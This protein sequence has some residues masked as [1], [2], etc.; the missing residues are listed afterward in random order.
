MH[1]E[2]RL[3]KENT[4][5]GLTIV[6]GSNNPMER[7]FLWRNLINK[8]HMMQ[9]FPWII[10][11]DFNTIR[12]PQEKVGGATW[13]NYYCEDL[14]NCIR[15]A[16]LDDLR[17]M[18]HLLMW[19][20]YSEGKRRITCKLDRALINDSWK[21]AF[22]NAMT[23]F[24]NPSISDHSLCMVRMG[25][26]EDCR[27]IPFKFFN[28]WTHHEN[29]LSIVAEVWSHEV[30]GNPM[31]NV[32]SK[33]K[34]LKVE[35]SL[36]RQKSKVYWL[37]KGDQNTKFFF[38]SI[39]GRRNRNSIYRIQRED[40]SFVHNMEEVKEEFMERF[41]SVLNGDEYSNVNLNKLKKLVKFWL[42]SEENDIL[43]KENS[44]EEIKETIFAMD[45]NKAPGLDGYGA[46][47]FKAG[48]NIIGDDVIKAIKHFFK[49]GHL[50]KEVN[51]TILAFVPKITNP[52]LCKDF[53][54]IACC[55]TL[56]KCIT[57]IMA[58]RLKAILLQFINKA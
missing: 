10:L 53:R 7:K 43:I 37:K 51:C 40:G 8:S 21:D 27:K 16:E 48:W 39:K 14:R 54:L 31:F 52:F 42:G 25:T 17:F 29:F 23:Y 20:N 28:L 18:G 4:S 58:N 50:L 32:I 5:I 26:I 12:D 2:V 57:K 35:E 3:V 33:L 9:N 49:T 24:L 44:V 6:Y 34:K 36:A 56:Y 45:N 1:C 11:G 19:S 38:K 30:Q 15:E 47:F 41:K 55:N 22:L 46:C 13:G